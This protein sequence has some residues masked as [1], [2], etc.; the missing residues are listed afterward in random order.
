M[1]LCYAANGPMVSRAMS[2]SLEHS[3]K[4]R[5]FANFGTAILQ[6]LGFR[7]PELHHKACRRIVVDF[8]P[9]RGRG[10][11]SARPQIPINT[12]SAIPVVDQNGTSAKFIP[13]VE[14]GK[15]IRR[16]SLRRSPKF[17]VSK[18]NPMNLR[19]ASGCPP[20]LRKT[21]ILPS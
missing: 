8:R 11:L 1:S 13:R 10:T 12:K 19:N 7:F 5:F 14:G 2:E 18:L 20:N 3:L 9:G 16:R 15:N 21:P 6:M 17:L 4:H